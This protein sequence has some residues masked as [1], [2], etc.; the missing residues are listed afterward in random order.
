[1]E[2]SLCLPGVT[3]AVSVWT[4]VV[5]S[6]E[7]YLAVCSPLS[8][9]FG[10]VASRHAALVTLAIWIAA[11]AT[12]SPVFLLSELQPIGESNSRHKCREVRLNK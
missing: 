2:A 5:I 6:M 4:L 11:M 3:V 8:Q 7:R 10:S 12:M 1:M 9:H